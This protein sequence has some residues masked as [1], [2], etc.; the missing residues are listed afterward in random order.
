MTRNPPKVSTS[1]TNFSMM[2][3]SSALLRGPQAPRLPTVSATGSHSLL[4]ALHRPALAGR[5]SSLRSV[6]SA[7][8]ADPDTDPEAAFALGVKHLLGQTGVADGRRSG[9][10]S[11]VLHWTNAALGGH[12][13]AQSALG[14][15]YLRG[16][17]DVARD[18]ALARRFLQQ[19]ADAGH[20]TSRHELGK[21]L[22]SDE[23]GVDV[24][25]DEAEQDRT[26]AA[27]AYWARAADNGHM[28]ASYDL[29]HL[30]AT[31]L[32]VERDE[33][34]AARLYTQ[35]AGKG[36]PEA[37]RALGSAYLHGRGVDQDD[38]RAAAHLRK[39]ADAG[40][41]AAQF[42]LGACYLMGRGVARDARQAAQLFFLA[43]E[44]GGVAEA[45]LCLAQLFERGEG[46]PA[47]R[48]K[49]VQYYQSAADAGLQA[50]RQ[51]LQRLGVD[52]DGQ[53]Q[54]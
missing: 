12:V 29:A 53:R 20:N 5:G 50:A 7:A 31:G 43:A 13:R 24:G 10:Q 6:S 2:R 52:T 33:A 18:A 16:H 54:D 19:A 35:A 40:L 46:V 3:A 11:A 21:I 17:E 22:L 47:D 45:Q 1:A 30:Y 49:A 48:A 28:A 51:A 32:H 42:D 8:G 23:A 41:A 26:A 44:A 25:T 36:M 4:A 34:R 39:A 27:L 38:T 37:H 14:L 15:L 9:A